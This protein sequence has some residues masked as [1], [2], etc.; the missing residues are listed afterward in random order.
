[1]LTNEQM[2]E[3]LK[4]RIKILEEIIKEDKGKPKDQ[5]QVVCYNRWIGELRTYKLILKEMSE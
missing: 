5:L 1:M 3:K 4:E 2:K